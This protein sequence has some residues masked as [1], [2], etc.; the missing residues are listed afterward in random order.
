MFPPLSDSFIISFGVFRCSNASDCLCE[1]FVIGSLSTKSCSIS[2][3]TC[4]RNRLAFLL[5]DGKVL[6]FFFICE[7]YGFNV[8]FGSKMVSRSIR[9]MRSGSMG[10]DGSG[11]SKL[12]SSISRISFRTLHSLLDREFKTSIPA[13]GVSCLWYNIFKLSFRTK[14]CTSFMVLNCSNI[15]SGQK[16]NPKDR[17]SMS[18][19]EG[20]YE[21]RFIM[22]KPVIG[23]A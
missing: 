15:I 10:V 2:P 8:A 9:S 4:V 7:R 17:T 22:L 6:D 1:R 14:R 20:W 16:P 19:L 11:L 3:I 12:S 13:F 5:E 18:S 21:E 23:W